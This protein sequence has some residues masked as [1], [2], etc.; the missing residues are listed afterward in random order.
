MKLDTFFKY[1]IFL[2]L[3][4]ALYTGFYPGKIVIIRT[5]CY[6]LFLFWFLYVYKRIPKN[7]FDTGNSFRFYMWFNAIMYARGTFNIMQWRDYLYFIDGLFP[8]FIF[9]L[10]LY[11]ASPNNLSTLF[12]SFM[13]LGIIMAIVNAF[14]PPTDATMTM[15]HNIMWLNIFIFFYPYIKKKYCIIIL[16]AAFAIISYDF[17]RRSIMLGYLIP[18]IILL[19]FPFIKMIAVRKL[20]FYIGTMLPLILLFL[21]TNNKFN[22]FEFMGEEYSVSIDEDTRQ[23]TVDSRTGIYKDVTEAVFESNQWYVPYIGLGGNG[24]VK[25]T[26]NGAATTGFKNLR[27]GQEAGMLNYIQYGGIWGIIAYGL[28]LLTAS[29]KAL[30]HSKNNFMLMMGTFL[31]FKFIYSFIEDTIETNAHTYY[32]FLWIGMCF[33][34]KFRMMT[35]SQINKW[36]NSFFNFHNS[37]SHAYIK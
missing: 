7:E 29:Y 14:F 32:H 1:S 11:L 34:T 22:I 8:A 5:I 16:I 12:K 21:F 26:N 17:D 27:N 28:F 19:G 35:N 37:K 10:C 23:L 36:I 33:N 31:L 2:I 15:A 9:P 20:M 24:K 25:V 6:I 3:F 13:T 30:F 4:P 18:L